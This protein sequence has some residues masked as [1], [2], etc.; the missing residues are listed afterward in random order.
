PWAMEFASG[1]PVTTE[2]D[3]RVQHV[4]L[5]GNV[6][7]RADLLLIAPA[8]ANTI[9]KIAHG[10]DDTPVTAFAIT[11]LGGGMPVM[12][13][14]AMHG[15]MIIHRIVVENIERLKRLGVVF[16]EP[17]AEE[18]KAKMPSID[19]IVSSVVSLIGKK[20]LQGKKVLVIAGATEEPIDDIRVVT[21]R[22][23]GE[24]GL[25]LAKAA[26][27]RGAKVELWMGR[28]SVE[29][30]DY[31]KTKRYQ[32]FRDLSEMTKRISHDI[33]LFPAA[34]SDFSPD[35][36][37]GKIPSE[38]GILKVVLRRNPKLID[39]M[40]KRFVVGFKAQVDVNDEDLVKE[41]VELIRRSR[42]ALVVANSIEDVGPGRTRVLLVTEDGLQE[43]LEGPKAKVADGIIDAVV[44]MMR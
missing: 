32:T 9:S 30:P 13:V 26:H 15:T 18:G 23:S 5:C 35:K 6:P 33:V 25:E 38:K 24:T 7:D 37:K 8:T 29:I 19:H 16:L 12:I 36:V 43:K 1:R 10:I 17:K 41:S 28:C 40:A 42:C 34:V 4:S 44:R 31:L 27:E 3:G 14:P 22:S 2:I 20:D 11:A 39:R 21:N